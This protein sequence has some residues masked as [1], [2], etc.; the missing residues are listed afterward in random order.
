[1]TGLGPALLPAAALGAIQPGGTTLEGGQV[2][3]V[4]LVLMRCTGLVIT[5][6]ILGHR[7]V[8]A[9]VKAGLAAVLAIGLVRSAT[10]A[11]GAL[12]ILLA[13]PIELLIGLALGTIVSL[14]FHAVELGGRLL[15]L[16]MGLSLGAVFNPSSQDSATALDPFFSLVAGLLFLALNLHVALVGV[17]AHSFATLPIGGGWPASLFQLVANLTAIAL[18]L[19]TRL[20]MPLA[21][22]LLLAELSIALLAR[23]IPQINVFFLGLPIKIL[24]GVAILVAALP[25]VLA[26]A[27][28]IFRMLLSSAS[29]GAV[30]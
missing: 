3:A 25:T 8:P 12:P 1:V 17:L 10:I 23:A 9:M 19:G 18:E 14:G 22:V 16:Q 30:R 15:S 20:V 5:A 4:F 28:G 24:A 21:L 11:P 2:A 6:P 26:G 27:T 7:A 13:A 29:A